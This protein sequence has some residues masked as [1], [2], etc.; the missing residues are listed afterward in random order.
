VLFY[1]L[2]I[3]EIGGHITKLQLAEKWHV[4]VRH[5][6][7][8]KKLKISVSRGSVATYFLLYDTL[9]CWKFNRLSSSERI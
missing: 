8:K 5:S 9:L 2:K 4:S 6:K 1:A 3:I 7:C